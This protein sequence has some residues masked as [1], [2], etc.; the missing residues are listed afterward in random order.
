[1]KQAAE[2]HGV[3]VA[4][5]AEVLLRYGLDALQEGRLAP[6]RIMVRGMSTPL[7]QVTRCK[8]NSLFRCATLR[9]TKRRSRFREEQALFATA[10]FRGLR[11]QTLP[12]FPLHRILKFGSALDMRIVT[13]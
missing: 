13:P 6:P 2:K 8:H 10:M 3:K 11:C 7:M 1:M 4:A 5:M 12:K 9:C